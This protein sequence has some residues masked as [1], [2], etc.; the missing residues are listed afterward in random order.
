[1][2][3][4]LERSSYSTISRYL[5]SSI[6]KIVKD[7][8]H[9]Y[10]GINQKK[11]NSFSVIYTVNKK[12]IWE[13]YKTYEE[14][15]GRKIEIEYKQSNGTFVPP[16]SRTVKEFLE[17]YVDHYGK[18]KWSFSTHS[19][20]SAL[21]NNYIIPNIGKM[22][23]KDCT[24]HNMDLFFADLKTENAVHQK[25]G[26][27]SELITDRTICDIHA[28]LN[29]AFNFAV[30]WE[31]VE[32]KALEL[33]D[34][35][36]LKV[37]MHLGLACSMRLGE[38]L[39]L[40]WEFIDFGD[41]DN[42]FHDAK[43]NVVAE[44]QRIHKHSHKER[45]VKFSFPEIKPNSKTKLVLKEP[46][47]EL[48]IR[49]I[50]IPPTVATI[51][52]QL[53]NQQQELMNLL[54][55]SYSNFDL[56]IAQNNGRPVEIRLIDEAFEKL[57]TK[58]KLPK[59]VFHSLRHLSTSL[60]LIYTNGDI[61]GVQGDN[62]HAQATMTLDVYEHI[63]DENRRKNA[64]IFEE[65]FYNANNETEETIETLIRKCI[66]DPE[67]MAKLIDILTNFSKKDY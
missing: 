29:N 59:V 9:N 57:I 46:K 52:W 55:N 25:G 37:C 6:I 43:L 38:I 15:Q 65:K 41:V 19:H 34:N 60:K 39:G 21:I 20:N 50:W 8:E 40:R 17:E 64:Q 61:K 26:P 56:V 66:N 36:N 33:C 12:Q 24:T 14:A 22:K 49:D 67:L 44:L 47:T 16:N 27:A 42:D 51:L 4:Y 45:D 18:T 13:T 31:Y 23:L 10:N 2:K 53:K 1:M 63:L 48:S 3:L 32:K 58:N 5:P 62:G 11:N 35:L 30:S 7:K 54:G 28:I